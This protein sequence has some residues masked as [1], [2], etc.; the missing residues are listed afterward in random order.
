MTA[1]GVE[2]CLFP[3]GVRWKTGKPPGLWPLCQQQGPDTAGGNAHHCRTASQEAGVRVP[4][5]VGK[6]DDGTA[7]E[8]TTGVSA[9][10]DRMGERQRN[11]ARKG[12]GAPSLSMRRK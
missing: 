11:V 2:G 12:Y 1:P 9:G 4:K 5:V 10:G 7:Q 6:D 8:R 3:T